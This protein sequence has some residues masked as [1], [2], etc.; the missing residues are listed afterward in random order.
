MLTSHSEENCEVIDGKISDIIKNRLRSS[1][2]EPKRAYET[3]A[4]DG[5]PKIILHSSK[6]F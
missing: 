5:T 6:K 2:C 3:D 4:L 1:K